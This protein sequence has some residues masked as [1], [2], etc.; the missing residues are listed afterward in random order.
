MKPVTRLESINRRQDDDLFVTCAGF[1]D[2]CLGVVAI[3]E[4]YRAKTALMIKFV[5]GRQQ[6]A[7]DRKRLENS[8]ALLRYFRGHAGTTIELSTSRYNPLELELSLDEQ[9]GDLGGTAGT[10][11]IDVSC[12]TRIQLL[13]VLRYLIANRPRTIRLLYTS[14]A[15]YASL[16]EREITQ[17]FEGL[18]L[19][20]Y[21]FGESAD[22]G[23]SPD[24]Y[25]LAALGHEGA[26]CLLAWRSLEPVR[27]VLVLPQ[28]RRSPDITRLT[29]SQNE[30][31]LERAEAGDPN[32]ALRQVDPFDIAQST[33]VLGNILHDFELRDP[34][35]M[36]SLVPGGPKPLVAAFAL[37]ALSSGVSCHIAYPLVSGY[38]PAYS[39]G[40]GQ[41]YEHRIHAPY[42][43]WSP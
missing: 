34:G 23:L 19:M 33:A 39:T 37:A 36:I 7:L 1:E 5:P 30:Q 25:L 6:R 3:G 35:G 20:P 26:R 42:E 22:L 4:G 17:G 12:F 21:S 16:D 18:L 38:D 15:Y 24:V 32:F 31:L 13:F 9:L 43:I 14:P 11:T 8:R 28:N 10:V 40:T 41:S 29:R 2:R 27:T